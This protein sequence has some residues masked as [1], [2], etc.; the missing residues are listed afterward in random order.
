MRNRK[1]KVGINLVFIDKT[2]KTQLSEPDSFQPAEF[3]M[4]QLASH[5][6]QGYSWMPT[7][8]DA[9]Q[10]RNKGA[11]NY[12]SALAID[13]DHDWTIEKALADPFVEAH[14][15]LV[16]PSSSHTESEHRFRIVFPLDDPILGNQ[17]I[18]YALK[19]LQ[20][21][22]P[23]ADSACIDPA[24][25]FYGAKGK[26]PVMV[27]D[28]ASVCGA[29]LIALGKALEE[30]NRPQQRIATPMLSS[31][32]IS[33]LDLVSKSNGE[34]IENGVGEG[35][36]NATGAAVARDLIGCERWLSSQGQRAIDAAEQLFQSYLGCCSPPLDNREGDTI[37]KSAQGDNPTPSTPTDQL[38]QRIGW[39]AA[40]R[41]VKGQQRQ[42]NE[43]PKESVQ[44]K[45]AAA[46]EDS[47][48]NKPSTP[49][50]DAVRG[51]VEN[52]SGAELTGEL[53]AIAKKFDRQVG[54]VKE[55]AADVESEGQARE[56]EPGTQ[57]SIEW[58]QQVKN[59]VLE[60]SSFLPETVAEPLTRIAAS[61][62]HDPEPYG[63]ALLFAVGG[64]AHGST[65]LRISDTFTQ[66]PTIYAAMVAKSG[67]KKT[68][69]Y[70]TVFE[71][72]FKVL[73]KSVTEKYE[74]D[75]KSYQ[76]E[77]ARWESLSKDERADVQNNPKPIEP[78]KVLLFS[79]DAT[80]EGLLNQ[81]AHYSESSVFYVNDELNGVLNSLN[82]YK[83]GNG[84][85]RESLLAHYEQQPVQRIRSS[86]AV[87]SAHDVRFAVFGA[88]TPSCL[89]S[90]A[91]DSK[92]GSGFASR[93]LFC[94]VRRV[95]V[96][97]KRNLGVDINNFLV[98]IYNAVHRFPPSELSLS[99]G[100][101]DLFNQAQY[102]WEKKADTKGEGWESNIWSKASGQLMRLT[103]ALHLLDCAIAKNLALE[104]PAGTVARAKVLL[105]FLINHGAAIA[106]EKSGGLSPKLDKLIN[107]A[108]SK[109]K[110]GL[111]VDE[112]ANALR[113]SVNGKT[114]KPK[115]PI[116]VGYFQAISDMRLGQVEKT[117]R[118]YKLFTPK[119][120][121]NCR[122][123][124]KPLQ[125]KD[126]SSAN[127]NAE[128]CRVAELE[129][130]DSDLD[131]ELVSYL[132][133]SAIL[134]N[135]NRRAEIVTE[136]EIQAN[137]VNSAA[138]RVNVSQNDSIDDEGLL[139]EYFPEVPN[140][141]G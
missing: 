26:E 35:G 141:G 87:T 59:H 105:D 15:G 116:V 88:V 12:A 29:D 54:T 139:D 52:Y 98:D 123:E 79:N 49:L 107:L 32:D 8:L 58:L 56:I 51:A 27:N 101:F 103:A 117:A 77:Q 82:S 81:A 50:I 97:L 127:T 1:F 104:I 90:L 30:Q 61:M 36:R 129:C 9:G 33:L 25:F 20:E 73:Q 122:I 5:I 89:D 18:K 38:E 13:I 134:G 57:E 126:S 44:A 62:G 39:I 99:D 41:P 66:P 91:K 135:D 95:P 7:I 94:P 69:I 22:I 71:R 43:S 85:D 80:I 86:G 48:I 42:R 6:G 68:S 55:I 16:I 106:I 133:N 140:H 70:K 136:E 125:S 83:G 67:S 113:E 37:W 111:T 34:A 47:T 110:A 121:P 130:R 53:A 11:A 102:F 114:V 119:E 132:G 45:L 17:E 118:S 31:T 96:M 124:P 137:S 24:R 63:L 100:A 128:D 138:S 10:R 112:A 108:K 93:F 21:H 74:D 131:A 19:G 109:G 2:G 92:D 64:I 60:L 75:L 28:E 3:T 46:G 4:E 14:A 84:A 72:P 76:A 120:L 65:S 23:V 115:A 40:G 78:K